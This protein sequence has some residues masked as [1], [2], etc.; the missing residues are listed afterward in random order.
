MC[1]VSYPG[2]ANIIVTF[3]SM[4]TEGKSTFKI[5]LTPGHQWVFQL[6]KTPKVLLNISLSGITLNILR[7]QTLNF[8]AKIIMIFVMHVQKNHDS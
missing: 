5:K 2:V 7:R 8:N 3:L 4:N 6:T 1:G